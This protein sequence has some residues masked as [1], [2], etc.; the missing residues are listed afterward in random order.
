MTKNAEKMWP[1]AIYVRYDVD[2]SDEWERKEKLLKEYCEKQ[3]YNVIEVFREVEGT[4]DYY[5]D[6]ISSI[7]RNRYCDYRRLI[8]FDMHEFA[9]TDEQI[10]AF[11]EVMTDYTVAVETIKDGVLGTDVLFGVTIHNNVMK[12]EVLQKA[13]AINFDRNPF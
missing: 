9:W 8:A 12:K 4:F 5:S 2:N 10:M 6:V 13:Q 7:M 11:Y 1:V 3:N